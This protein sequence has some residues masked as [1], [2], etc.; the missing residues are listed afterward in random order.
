[1]GD[2]QVTT[3]RVRLRVQGIVQGVGFR[4]FVYRVA[5]QHDLGGFVLNDGKGVVVELE[6]SPGDVEAFERDLVGQAPPLARIDSVS[7]EDIPPRGDREFVIERSGTAGGTT[8]IPP[9]AATCDR[10]LAETMDPTNRRYRYPFTNCTDCGPRYTIIQGLPYDRPLTTMSTFGM[11]P[12][13]LAEYTDPMDR[14]FHAQPNACPR[15]GPRLTLMDPSG[16]ELPVADPIE[17]VRAALARGEVVAIKGLGGFHLACDPY[18]QA[19]V[20]D[21]RARKG[22]DGKPLAVMARDLDTVRAL[23]M[24]SPEEEEA[25]TSPARPIV[26][27]RRRSPSP[28]AEG[29]AAG[30]DT[31]GVMLPYTPLHHLLL[32]PGGLDVLVMTSGN[33]SSEPIVIDDG[34]AVERLGPMVDLI[35]GNDRPIHARADDSVVRVMRDEVRPL[36]RSRGY[37]PDPVSLPWGGEDRQVLGVGA[38]LKNTVCLAKGARAFLSPH[39][40]DLDHPSTRDVLQWTVGHLSNLLDLHPELVVHDQHPDYPNTA[41]ANTLGLPTLGLQHHH[42]HA[43]ACLGENRHRG[44]A[45][46]LVLDGTGYG[47]DGTIWGGE[48]LLVDGLHMERLGHLVPLPL[49]GGDKAVKEPWRM[50]LAVLANVQAGAPSFHGVEQAKVAAMDA[51]VRGPAAAMFPSTSAMGRLFDAAAALLDLVTEARFEGHGPMV[52]EAEA[53]AWLDANGRAPDPLA[54]T[55]GPDMVLDLTPGM[56]EL[57]GMRG[58]AGMAAA[59]FHQSVIQGL[60]HLAE[61]LTDRTGVR[62]V[63]LTGGVLQ[64]RV[65]HDG[66]T[67]ALEVR[68]LRVLTHR[69]VPA[70]DGGISLGQAWAGLLH[71]ASGSP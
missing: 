9:D 10:C 28:L 1:M 33:R 47:T 63:A 24:V 44:P 69:L 35:L 43:L 46:A 54:W 62:V 51:L 18:S 23:A 57:P 27:L 66:L 12:E 55:L 13:C 39:I 59:M 68:G 17:E 3:V 14:R 64:N 60:A 49:P 6:G 58:A 56:A 70:N 50:G 65:I 8:L 19:A 31:I 4:P 26:L 32:A 15:C 40:G 30:L 71:L 11:C 16:R 41:W 5:H 37:A 45:L 20:M 38:F 2:R 7:R 48:A 42:A 29:V 21:L 52:L 34:A 53:R 36:R 25:L 61:V 67:R 22:R